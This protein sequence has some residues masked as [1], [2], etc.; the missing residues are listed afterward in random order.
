MSDESPVVEPLT[1]V[2]SP[3]NVTRHDRM[4]EGKVWD[5]VSEDFDYNGETI[6]REL[7]DHPGAVAVLALDDQDRVLLIRQYRHPVRARDWELPAGLL[8]EA[9]ESPVDAARREL[10]EEVDLAAAQWDVLA[11]YWTSPGGSNETLRI[12]LARQLTELDA[13]ERTAEEADIEK[14]WVSLDD[15]LAAILARR[16]QNPSLTVGVLAAVASRAGG[17]TS[18]GAADTPWDRHPVLGNDTW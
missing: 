2:R 13:F 6:T 12:Y 9:G 7:L 18:L 10:A 1:D 16:T 15:A 14:R 11:E 4:F 3:V 5:V 8:D 17:W